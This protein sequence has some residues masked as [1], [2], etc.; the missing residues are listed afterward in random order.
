MESMPSHE[1]IIRLIEASIPE[2]LNS[3]QD[4]IAIFV[5]ACMLKAGFTLVGL[6]NELST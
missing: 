1:E 4:A 2:K 3:A 5:H 6:Q